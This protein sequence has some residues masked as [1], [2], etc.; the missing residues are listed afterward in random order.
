MDGVA[1]YLSGSHHSHQMDSTV[2]IGHLMTCRRKFLYK[3]QKLQGRAIVGI[4]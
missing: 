3:W 4:L 2:T 1:L